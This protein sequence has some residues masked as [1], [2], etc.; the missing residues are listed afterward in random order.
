[1]KN[2]WL[3]WLADLTVT[4]GVMAWLGFQ[5]QGKHLCDELCLPCL[6]HPESLKTSRVLL[7]RRAS[8]LVRQPYPQLKLRSLGS[9]Q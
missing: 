4:L 3:E 2:A 9:Y 1:M 5:H 6:P 8:R 7:R